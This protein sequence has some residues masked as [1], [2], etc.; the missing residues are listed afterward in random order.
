MQQLRQ[1]TEILHQEISQ[2]IGYLSIGKKATGTDRFPTEIFKLLKVISLLSC[3]E[4]SMV[5]LKSR[6]VKT[7][8]I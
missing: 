7:E 6:A 3:L 1:E 8:L 2:L 5:F 4:S